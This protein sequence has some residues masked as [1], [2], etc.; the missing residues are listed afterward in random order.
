MKIK[1]LQLFHS[2]FPSIYFL[3]HVKSFLWGDIIV[4]FINALITQIFILKYLIVKHNWLWI[5]LCDE[6]YYVDT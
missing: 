3:W 2:T 5:F 4:T 1:L 6:K